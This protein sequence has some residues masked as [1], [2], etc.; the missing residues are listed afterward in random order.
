MKKKILSIGL[1]IAILGVT[2]FMLTGCGNNEDNLDENNNEEN[3]VATEK[4][5]AIDNNDNYYVIIKGTKFNAGDKISDVSKVG[6]KQDSRALD[7]KISK[8]T[9]M[10]GAGRIYDSNN[11]S[12]CNL[13]PYNSTESTITVADSVIG[14]LEVGDYQYD[15]IS[16]E[17]LALD[18]E[19]AG[20]I[21][22]GS[23]YEDVVK[24]FGETDN[25]YESDSLGYKKYNYKS[26]ET[27]RSYEFTIDKDGKVSRIYWQNLVFND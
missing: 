6:L 21:K 15:K 17:I 24:V 7:E 18:V 16:D 12:V 11:K 13:T 8:N 26:E 4:V 20:G 14:G 10:I 25:I 27:Y 23:S 19:V 3:S 22:L 5:N 2:L 9:Y 1:I